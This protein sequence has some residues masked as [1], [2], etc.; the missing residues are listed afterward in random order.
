MAGMLV[1]DLCLDGIATDSAVTSMSWTNNIT[2]SYLQDWRYNV[3]Y[4]SI[5]PHLHKLLAISHLSTR[6]LCKQ[7]YLFN[8]T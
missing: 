2:I 7:K 5:A 8:I 6:P 4:N 3:P 1:A